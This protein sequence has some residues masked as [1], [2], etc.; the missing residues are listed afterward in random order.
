MFR[1]LFKKIQYISPQSSPNPSCNM[2][3]YLPP[4][5]G[6]NQLFAHFSLLFRVGRCRQ[7]YQADLSLSSFIFHQF[8]PAP[9][10]PMKILNASHFTS[11]EAIKR[12][13]VLGLGCWEMKRKLSFIFNPNVMPLPLPSSPPSPPP[14]IKTLSYQYFNNLL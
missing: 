8:Y 14:P 10:L 6:I 13:V 3:C 12:Q 5:E 1:R 4:L 9:P 7:P 2:K 11:L